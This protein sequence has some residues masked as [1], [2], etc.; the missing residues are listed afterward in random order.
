MMLSTVCISVHSSAFGVLI[1]IFF[2]HF[3]LVQI[4]KGLDASLW[5]SGVCSDLDTFRTFEGGG[6]A[7]TGYQPDK[8]VKLTRSWTWT[9]GKKMRS[10]LL[11][12][13]TISSICGFINGLTTA[14]TGRIG[15]ACGSIGGIIS[16]YKKQKQK[17]KHIRPCQKTCAT[18]RTGTM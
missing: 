12:L 4:S 7:S 1:A 18:V 6:G 9:N 5:N 14:R 3:L 10:H 17:Q 2:R 8:N 16:R 11:T 13:K 15:M